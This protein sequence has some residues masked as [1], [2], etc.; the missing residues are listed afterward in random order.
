MGG[1]V[2]PLTMDRGWLGLVQDSLRIHRTPFL[3][4]LSF[5]YARREIWHLS[6]S[7]IE[8]VA[9]KL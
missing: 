6:H 2:N 7:A 4:G 5:S 3:L 8:S 1:V 9:L